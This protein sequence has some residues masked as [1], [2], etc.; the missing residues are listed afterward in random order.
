MVDEDQRARLVQVV[1]RAEAD[2]AAL[3]LRQPVDPAARRAVERHLVAVAGEKVLAEIL[4]DLLEEV[5]QVADDRVVAQHAV[6][7]LRDVADK[8]E[9]EHGDQQDRDQRPRAVRQN[10]GEHCPPPAFNAASPRPLGQ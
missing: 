4:A 7:L 1:G 9:R 10:S 2:H 8:D 6:L 3:V 5:A